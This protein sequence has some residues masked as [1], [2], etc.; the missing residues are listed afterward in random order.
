MSNMIKIDTFSK[1][2]KAERE[3]GIG[4]IQFTL[5]FQLFPITNR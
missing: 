3:A 1:E 4:L 5:R 2:N